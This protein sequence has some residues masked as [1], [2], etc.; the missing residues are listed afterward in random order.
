VPELLGNRR[1]H[2]EDYPDLQRHGPIS[3]PPDV[4]TRLMQALEK[5]MAEKQK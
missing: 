5:K 3:I 1:H 4:E 2:Q